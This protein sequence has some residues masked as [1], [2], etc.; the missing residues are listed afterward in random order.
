MSSP[1]VLIGDPDDVLDLDSNY[2]LS[3]YCIMLHTRPDINAVLT[4]GTIQPNPWIPA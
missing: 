4:R 2:I 3:R 1:K